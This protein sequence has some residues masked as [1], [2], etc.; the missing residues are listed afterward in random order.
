MSSM[1]LTPPLL[2]AF[3]A[4]VGLLVGFQIGRYVAVRQYLRGDMDETNND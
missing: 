3:C 2:A 1:F 4:Y